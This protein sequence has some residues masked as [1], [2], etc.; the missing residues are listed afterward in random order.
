MTGSKYFVGNKYESAELM[1]SYVIEV[2]IRDEWSIGDQGQTNVTRFIVL[3]NILVV[4]R[5]FK[6]ARTNGAE[7]SNE[8]SWLSRF[9]HQKAE[10]KIAKFYKKKK[11]EKKCVVQNASCHI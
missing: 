2:S 6:I 10:L 7:F 11:K 1:K 4:S 9:I 3:G 5:E 8:K